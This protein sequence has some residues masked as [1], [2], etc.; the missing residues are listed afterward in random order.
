MK[1]YA[2]FIT[3]LLNALSTGFFLAWSVSIILG[4]TT[5]RIG[6]NITT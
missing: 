2:L 6:I 5:K 1:I 3:V 4:T